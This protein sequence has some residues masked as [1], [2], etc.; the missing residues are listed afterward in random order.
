MDKPALQPL[1]YRASDV[2]ALLSVSTR[3]VWAM[4]AAGS[5]GPSPISLSDRLTRWDAAE[6]QN[7]WDACRTAGRRIGREEWLKGKGGQ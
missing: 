6:I 2:G 7:W 5:L 4:H 1:A 3:Q